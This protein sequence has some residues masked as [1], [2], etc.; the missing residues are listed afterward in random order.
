MPYHLSRAEQYRQKIDECIAMAKASTS[1]KVEPTITKLPRIIFTSWK[2][3]LNWLLSPA[4]PS[5]SSKRSPA[6]P[7][8]HDLAICWILRWPR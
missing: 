5:S 8:C 4:A 3:T 7:P 2:Q 6:C 1:N